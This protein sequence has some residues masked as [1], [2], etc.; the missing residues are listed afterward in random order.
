MLFKLEMPFVDARVQ[1]LRLTRWHK[2]EADRVDYGEKLCD[3]N[4]G[5][6]VGSFTK[7]VLRALVRRTVRFEYRVTLVSSDQGYL[8][9]ISAAAGDRIDVGQV[10]ALLSTQADEEIPR[11]ALKGAETSSFRIVANLPD[12]F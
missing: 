10:L 12:E 8:R 9:T 5:G 7:R 1:W 3:L 6:T 2:G 4:A 11:D